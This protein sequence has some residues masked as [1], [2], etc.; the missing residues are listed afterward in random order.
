MNIQVR[1]LSG[2]AVSELKRVQAQVVMLERQLAAAHAGNAAFAGGANA[3]GRSM[4]RWGSQLQWTG[5]QLEYNWTLPLLLAG[6]AATKWALE[7]D[8][9]FTRVAKVYGDASMSAEVMKNEL[10]ALGGALTALSNKFGVQQS[11]VIDIAAAW[12]AAGASGIGLA[13]SVETTLKAMILGEMEAAKATEALISIQVQYQFSSMELI[14]TLAQLNIVENQTGVSMAGLVEGFARAAGVARSAGVDTQHLAAMIAAISPAAGTAAQAGN[15][16]KTIISRLLKPTREASEVWGLMGISIEDA[17]WKSLNA[18]QRLE[19]MAQKFNTLDDAQ[20]GVVSA[21]TASV[22]QINKFDVLMREIINPLGFYQRALAATADQAQYLAQAE[23]ELNTVLDSSPRQLQI[24]WA[25]LQNAMADIIQPLIPLILMLADGLKQL[26]LQF[27]ELD[28]A[29][30]KL[31]LALLVFLAL[32]GPLTRYIASLALLAGTFAMGF[33]SM[34]SSIASATKHLLDFL[35]L[36]FSQAGKAILFLLAPLIK[37]GKT[38]RQALLL[39]LAANGARAAQWFVASMI[40]MSRATNAFF[41]S[42]FTL[43]LSGKFAAAWSAISATMLT[44]W[45]TTMGMMRTAF[46]AAFLVMR[47]YAIAFTAWLINVA[48]VQIAAAWTRLM[49][50]MVGGMLVMMTSLHARMMAGFWFMTSGPMWFFAMQWLRFTKFLGAQWIVFTMM[51]NSWLTR[52]FVALAAG[53]LFAFVKVWQSTIVGLSRAWLM[54]TLFVQASAAKAL[55]WVAAGPLMALRKAWIALIAFLVVSWRAVMTRL[56]IAWAVVSMAALAAIGRAMTALAAGAIVKLRA[57]WVWLTAII[58]AGSKAMVAAAGRAFMSLAAVMIGPWG[59]AILA[60]A[61][62]IYWLRDEIVQVWDNIVSWFKANGQALATAFG[63]IVRFF[64]AGVNAIERA[65]Y[66]LPQSVQNAIRK[67]VEVVASAAIQ[68]YEWLSYLNPFARHSP[69]LVDQVLAGMRVITDAYGDIKAISPPLDVARAKIKALG[70]AIDEQERVVTHWRGVLDQLQ[71][72]AHAVGEQLDAA[73]DKLRNF[74][75]TP[76]AGMRA[77]E[78]QLFNNEMAQKRLRLEMLKIEDAVGPIDQLQDRLSKITGEI[79]LLRGEQNALR[80]AGA[81]SDILSVYDEQIRALENQQ[82][83][84]GDQVRPINDLQRQL[85]ELQRAGEILDLERALRFDP[86]LRQ[87]DQLANGM[88]EMPFDQ[89]IAG[90]TA[91]KAEVARLTAAYDQAQAAVRSANTQYEAESL[92]LAQMRDEY[93]AL[94]KEVREAESA[95]SDLEQTIRKTSAA[96]GPTSPG[97]E[98]FLAATGGN[99]DDVGGTSGI[100]REMPGIEDQSALI[101]QYTKDLAAQTSDMFSALDMFEPI[102]NAWNRVWSWITTNIGPIVALIG[103]LIKS[104][105]AGIPN[106]FE[107]FAGGASGVAQTLQDI[108][109][110]IIT[111]LSAIWSFIAPLLKETLAA[112]WDGV[113]EFWANLKP[114]LEDLREALGPLGEIFKKVWMVAKPI[115]AIFIGTIA[116]FVSI[117]WNMLNNVIAPVF[118]TIGAIIGGVLTVVA[119]IIKVIA[120]ILTLDWRLAWDGILDIVR[121]TFK[122]MWAI[123]EGGA[124]VIWGLVSGL[125][126]GVV[127]F[128]VWLWD[129]LVGHSIIPDMIRSIV[130]WF[131]NLPSWVLSAIASLLGRMVEWAKSVWNATASAM[132]GEWSKIISW[133]AGRP[134]AVIDAMIILVSLLRRLGTDA[135][136]ALGNSLSSIWNNIYGWL[137]GLPGAAATALAGMG[138]AV[139]NAVKSAWNGAADFLNRNVIGNI[140]RVIGTF[141]ISIPNLPTFQRGGVIPGPVSATDNVIIRARTGEGVIIPEAV[142]ALGGERGVNAFNAYFRNGPQSGRSVRDAAYHELPG[143]AN[144]GVIGA[145]SSWFKSNITDR[146]SNLIAQGSGIALDAILSP[147]SGMIRGVMPDGFTEDFVVGVINKWRSSAKSWGDQKDLTSG[148]GSGVWARPYGPWPPRVMGRVAANTS[149]AVAF[150]RQMFGITNIGTLGSR[151]NA[152]D[153]PYGKALD[154]MIPGWNTPGGI[155]LGNRVASY[156]G[157]NPNAFGTKY[158]IWRKRFTDGRGWGPYGHPTG[159][160]NPTLDHFDHVHVSLFDKGGNLKPGWNLSYNGTGQNEAV[161]SPSMTALWRTI[162]TQPTAQMQA[163]GYGSVSGLLGA[164]GRRAAEANARVGGGDSYGQQRSVHV[165]INGDLSFPNI[166]SGGDA[167]ELIKNLES[168]A[169]M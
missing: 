88:E 137:T 168:L 72:S 95:I 67:V 111:V 37:L 77:M 85:E 153:H 84:I 5:R 9:A 143:F 42:A 52:A 169:R 142:K 79:E 134:Q 56:M 38:A 86:L 155:A 47:G 148:A 110:K 114:G 98:S 126:E 59:V 41:M 118:S 94:S 120:G 109:G 22:Y 156:F 151:P 40:L 49:T 106:P 45:A 69:S 158:L 34:A 21:V 149:A 136:N 152:S 26:V 32:I 15:A 119:G 127:D 8:K 58:V 101:E 163:G 64:Q 7:N 147:V 4:M 24:I 129:V 133:L 123:I 63:P 132:Q 74:S 157:A 92:K 139:A 53:P 50:F 78:D 6:A 25:T 105:F 116:L 18:S 154:V 125:V 65:F 44:V 48:Y 93:E 112:I 107:S 36:P 128:F 124:R 66:A 82:R 62:L 1:V 90:I 39:G 165:T 29:V 141:G 102:R 23:R 51:M 97:A 19:L 164:A 144:G 57:A 20:K 35:R 131:A 146:L 76:I 166:K 122:A 71:D 70:S 117:L 43:L 33:V 14:D 55:A 162:T 11:E 13:R 104:A 3:S 160:S 83:A 103:N 30:Q 108:G 130:E 89:I 135:F 2:Q 91:S 61:G 28:P 150:V 87:I 100:G 113:Q 159:G 81:G 31:T 54:F 27:K 10:N 16:L 167:D 121:G 161:L 68:V 99:F 115:L 75:N 73:K 145:A 80:S 46:Y 60:V 12:A 140:N 96:G 17:S 138:N